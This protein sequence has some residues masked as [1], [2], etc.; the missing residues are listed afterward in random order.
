MAKR[1]SCSQAKAAWASRPRWRGSSAIF[2]GN[3]PTVR[4]GA[5]RRRQPADDLAA[6]ACCDR[7][8]QEL[9]RRYAL[10]LPRAESPDEIIRTFQVALTSLPAVGPGGPGL[11]R[12]QPARRRRPGRDAHLAA[13]ASCRRT[14]GCSAA[15]PR[16]RNEAP[17]VLTAFG[18]RDCRR[19]ADGAADP[20][21][22]PRTS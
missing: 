13:R 11:R 1:R 3:T 7:L 17:R 9:Q 20:G 2:A 4:A 22:A 8:T 14:C 12:P 16:A 21:R 18:E 5:L 15:P 10:T 6:H 19:R